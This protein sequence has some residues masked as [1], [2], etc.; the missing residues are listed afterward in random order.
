MGTWCCLC[1]SFSSS[2]RSLYHRR[3][4]TEMA[5]QFITVARRGTMKISKNCGEILNAKLLACGAGAE[6]S[7]RLS[8][9]DVRQQL[10]AEGLQC[11]NAMSSIQSTRATW[12]RWCLWKSDHAVSR[13][14]SL[15][16]SY[17]FLF[18]P[19]FSSFHFF[20]L[21]L[22]FAPCGEQHNG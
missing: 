21:V 1:H 3:F 2:T 5:F 15:S 7:P 12:H 22:R 17:I 11:W 9:I 8:A 10:R 4:T 13:W 14:C 18:R 16:L 6:A 20:L 19:P